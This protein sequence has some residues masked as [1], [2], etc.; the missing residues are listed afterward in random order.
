MSAH[1]GDQTVEPHPEQELERCPCYAEEF[2]GLLVQEPWGIARKPSANE[3]S[4]ATAL[5]W[6][7][8]NVGQEDADKED[9][10]A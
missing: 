6:D 9:D 1:L 5:C 7:D 8:Y 2:G 3:R 10:D 4:D